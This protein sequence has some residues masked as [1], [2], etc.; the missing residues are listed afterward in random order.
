MTHMMFVGDFNT[1]VLDYEY[2]RKVKK[3]FQ[4]DVST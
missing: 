2:N 4:F 1:N 3:F